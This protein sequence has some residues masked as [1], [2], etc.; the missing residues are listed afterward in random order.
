MRKFVA[1]FVAACLCACAPQRQFVGWSQSDGSYSRT[2]EQDW[3]ACQYEAAV[4]TAGMKA[5]QRGFA[6]AQLEP[7][8]MN[9]RGW[10]PR[11]R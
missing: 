6:Q 7:K 5:I 8:C 4:A 2:A 1:I 10:V 11:Y 9:A 3:T